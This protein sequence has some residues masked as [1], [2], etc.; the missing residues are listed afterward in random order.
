MSLMWVIAVAF[1]QTSTATLFKNYIPDAEVFHFEKP[2]FTSIIFGPL[3]F[4]CGEPIAK[5][6]RGTTTIIFSR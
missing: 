2:T 6:Y 1:K 5:H 3:N 4:L